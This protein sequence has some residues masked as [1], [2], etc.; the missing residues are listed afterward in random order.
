MVANG[1][2][3]SIYIAGRE[4][5]AKILAAFPGARA[6][7]TTAEDE[8]LGSQTDRRFEAI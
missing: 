8:W 2:A 4:H 6:V 3:T 5:A 1:L 7:V